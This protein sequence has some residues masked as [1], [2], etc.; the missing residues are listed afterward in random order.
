[1]FVWRAAWDSKNRIKRRTM[2]DG[3]GTKQAIVRTNGRLWY[4]G[5]TL[6]G[7]VCS[8]YWTGHWDGGGGEGGMIR[9]KEGLETKEGRKGKTARLILSERSWSNGWKR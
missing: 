3:I 5:G 8:A 2:N 4:N 1:V 7:R 6:G 9:G